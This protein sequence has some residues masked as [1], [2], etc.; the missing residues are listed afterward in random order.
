LGD[1][2]SLS[3][4]NHANEY[5]AY[6]PYRARKLHFR[7]TAYT[8]HRKSE[9]APPL[10]D[11]F[12]FLAALLLAAPLV[13]KGRVSAAATLFIAGATSISW[14][15]SAG[16]TI[17]ELIACLAKDELKWGEYHIFLL[18]F[19]I[20][21]GLLQA[22]S[23]MGSTR[24]KLAIDPASS[25]LPKVSFISSSNIGEWRLVTASGDRLLLVS[26]AVNKHDL[27]FKLVDPSEI[28]EI[29]A[30]GKK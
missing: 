21:Y 19:V 18:Y 17:G 13:L 28:K 9:G 7:S 16:L 30:H 5:L 10:G 25:A 12:L 22:P 4:S 11:N 20:L 8:G 3:H 27:R 14:A 2:S 1:V 6:K 15:I 26:L 29:F 23:N 24:A